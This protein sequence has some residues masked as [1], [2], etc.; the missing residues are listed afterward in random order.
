MQNSKE[1]I[2]LTLTEMI[3]VCSVLTF[4]IIFEYNIN[5]MRTK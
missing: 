5:Q 4:L 2:I 1:F 3:I